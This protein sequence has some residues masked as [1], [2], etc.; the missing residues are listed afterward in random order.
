MS[1]VDFSLDGKV[2]IVTGG[3]K[4]IGR[5]IALAFAEHGADVVIAARGTEA[6]ERTRLEIAATGRR[7]LAVRADM[8]EDT[9]CEQ[10]YQRTVDEFGGVDILVNNA[11]AVSLG[12]LGKETGAEFAKIMKVNVWAPLYLS[13]LCR[14]SMRVRGGGAIIN[15]TSNEGIRPSMGIGT[16]ALSKA[17]MINMAQLLGKE[18]ARN[19]IRVTCIAP[20][21]IRTELA[22]PLVEAVESSGSPINPQKRV[23]EPHEIAGMA[24][25][26]ASPAG[27]FATGM[28][29]VVD[30]GEISAGP[31]DVVVLTA[32]GSLAAGSDKGGA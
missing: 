26:L 19:S 12:T 17:A 23:G 21:L 8:A 18:W 1:I 32:E 15:I 11:A 27:A 29:Y 10:L 6:L 24:L 7:A 31:G 22:Q 2:A 16:Y 14:E 13:R 28:T 30:G 4:G 20:G 9:D 3:S 25:F 5:A